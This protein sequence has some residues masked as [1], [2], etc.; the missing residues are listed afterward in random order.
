M[1]VSSGR[2]TLRILPLFSKIINS[3]KLASLKKQKNASLILKIRE[4]RWYLTYTVDN[5]TKLNHW[6]ILVRLIRLIHYRLSFWDCLT[7]GRQGS[8]GLF[9]VN[10]LILQRSGAEWIEIKG[11]TMS[12]DLSIKNSEDG[13]KLNQQINLFKY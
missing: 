6:N 9:D 1:T 3:R 2:H 13:S 11:I 4:Y 8:A 5:F 7:D 10:W 12:H